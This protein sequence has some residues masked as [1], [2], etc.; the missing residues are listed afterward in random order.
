MHLWLKV[1]SALKP[2]IDVLDRVECILPDYI[3]GWFWHMNEQWQLLVGNTAGTMPSLSHCPLSCVVHILVGTTTWC[4]H[5]LC[6]PPSLPSTFPDNL[7]TLS[8]SPPTL[9]SFHIISLPL[10]WLFLPPFLRETQVLPV[11][12]VSLEMRAMKEGKVVQ[13]YL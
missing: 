11:L 9:S 6:L 8:F 1:H 5:L 7:Q 4:S 13:E 2:T 10:L 3:K 12:R